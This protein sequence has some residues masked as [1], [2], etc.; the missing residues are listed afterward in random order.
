MSKMY[1]SAGVS[2]SRGYEAVSRIKQYVERTK[3]PGVIGDFGLFGGQFDLSEYNIP[4]PLLVSGTAGV[5]TKLLIAQ[6]ENKHDP[7]GID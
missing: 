4:D 5:G 2:L 1:E 7:N 6:E 3:I